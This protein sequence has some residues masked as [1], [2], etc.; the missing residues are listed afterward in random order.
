MKWLTE[1]DVRHLIAIEAQRHGSHRA[2]ARKWGLTAPFLSMVRTGRRA[3][4]PRILKR[5]G[6]TR[7]TLYRA[8]PARP[9][10]A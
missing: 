8:L 7:H 4:S 3:P 10:V 6:L 1:T 2:L 9:F 5:L